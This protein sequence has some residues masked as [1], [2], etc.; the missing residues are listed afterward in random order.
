MLI[1]VLAG[2]AM[3]LVTVG[4]H[5]FALRTISTLHSKWRISRDAMVLLS[6]CGAFLAHTLEIAC[7]AGTYYWLVYGAAVGSLVGQI[8]GTF[9]DF[10]YYST[11]M[12]TSLGIGDISPSEH[13]RFV[14]SLEGL[15]GL[16][17]IGWTT[18]FT[19][20]TMRRFWIDVQKDGGS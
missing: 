20:L 17:L 5:F 4:I 8:S 15:N 19:F 11:V 12:Y 18:S 13:L 1:A 10:Y 9:M 16:V 14:S 7:Y 2:A 6:V 3:V